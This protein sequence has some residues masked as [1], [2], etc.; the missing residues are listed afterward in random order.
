MPRSGQSE[1]VSRMASRWSLV[2]LG[3]VWEVT[4]KYDTLV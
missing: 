3:K 1:G 4:G 2:V